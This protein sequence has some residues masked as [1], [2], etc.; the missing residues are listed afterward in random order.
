[1]PSKSKSN[2][3]VNLSRA[4]VAIAI[5][6]LAANESSASVMISTNPTKN[7]DCV[8]GVC[9][10]TAK[11]AVMNVSDL[12]NMLGASDVTIRTNKKAVTIT[13]ASALTWASANRLTLDAHFNVT[14]H[15][16][17][18]VAGTGGLTMITND[19][20]S[21]G[22]V[23]FYDGGSVDFWDTTSSLI[24]NGNSYTLVD[25]LPALVSAVTTNPAGYYALSKSYNAFKD[26]QYKSSPINI[27][28]GTFEGLGHTISNFAVSYKAGR[29][30]KPAA[31]IIQSNGTVRDI[32]FLKESVTSNYG[33]A[34]IVGVN[35]G[36][37]VGCHTDGT[38]Q[39]GAIE[40]RR[41]DF[42]VWGAGGLVN[43]N[44]GTIALSY[45]TAN[46]T[47]VY[48][49]GGLA[50]DNSGMI[51]QSHALGMIVVTPTESIYQ[52]A[53]GLVGINEAHATVLRSYA[54]G[55]VEEDRSYYPI[56]GLVGENDGTVSLS[57][58][59]GEIQAQANGGG[60][61]GFN[62]YSGLIEYS[63]ETGGGA[64]G[65]LSCCNRGTIIA[66]YAMGAVNAQDAG[67]LVTTNEGTISQSYST[68]AVIGSY[69]VGGFI[70]YDD[71]KN[72]SLQS[73]YWDTDTSGITN[74]SKGAGNI[75]YDPGIEGLTSAI[76]SGGLP[77]GF[78]PN[79]WGESA[80][81]NNGLPYLLANPPM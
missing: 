7:M 62:N 59:S 74:L 24:I 46:V 47:G 33:A 79:V 67:G 57:H 13:V 75:P 72:G 70:G 69:Y 43:E 22:D 34:G 21:G 23:I 38:V 3:A 49:G 4:V 31:L 64:E 14:F 68:G 27:L 58:S 10:P 39:G 45:S 29:N 19:G 5:A 2:F 53:G 73:D 28:S 32:G 20:G 71:S 54:T 17:I 26:R 42:H 8:G 50:A 78:D 61:V 37:V 9:T 30:P 48:R 6:L 15:A 12:A 25:S 52:Y 55:N 63:Y 76:L 77:A 35:A 51:S 65:G 11:S 1:M 56:G 36:A 60:L 41:G 16:P 66:S 81:I 80:S 18:E 44:Q 40:L